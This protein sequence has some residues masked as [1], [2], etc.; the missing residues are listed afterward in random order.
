MCLTLWKFQSV[1]FLFLYKAVA[2]DACQRAMYPRSQSGTL[3][4]RKPPVGIFPFAVVWSMPNFAVF[5][6]SEASDERKM[7]KMTFPPRRKCKKRQNLR[8]AH[9]RNAKNAKNYVSSTGE[10][11]KTRKTTFRPRAKCKKRE[12]LRF[13]HGRNAKISKINVSA[14]AEA[15]F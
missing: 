13:A 15:F 11:Q 6:S 3:V 1:K 8:F 9:G 5:V 12:K 14:T 4:F 7:R 10:I 2:G